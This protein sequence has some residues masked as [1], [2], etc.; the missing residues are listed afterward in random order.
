MSGNSL[1]ALL[2]WM[3]EDSQMLKW[4]MIVALERRK[5]N[6][7]MIQEYI[8]RFDVGSYLP[9]IRGEITIV[10]NVYMNVVHDFVMDVPLL[11]FENAN[12][13]D[14]RAMLTMSVVGGSEFSLKRESF[15]WKA[16]MV[17]EIDPL[18]GPKLYLD[19]L[20]D[21]VPGNVELNG[22][23]ILDLSKSDNFRLTVGQTPEEHRLGGG[24]FKDLFNTLPADKRIWPLGS[25]EHGTSDVMRPESFVLRTQS[26]GAAAHDPRS[27]EHGNGAILA[28]IRM[29]GSDGGNYP[30][31]NYKYLIPDD[32]GKDYSA[33]VLFDWARLSTELGWQKA[34]IDRVKSLFAT[35]DLEY[36]YR[37]DQIES[38]TVKSGSFLVSGELEHEFLVKTEDGFAVVTIHRQPSIVPAY[39][40]L[41]PFTLVFSARGATMHW[42]S[43]SVE[44]VDIYY[45]ENNSDPVGPYH[46][47]GRILYALEAVFELK[48]VVG[49]DGV[50][51]PVISPTTYDFYITKSLSEEQLDWSRA[52]VVPDFLL[53]FIALVLTAFLVAVHI[54]A[55]ETRVRLLLFVTL[56]FSSRFKSLIKSIIKLNFGQAM[57]TVEIRSP[58][59]IAYF[60]RINP[61]RTSF[62]INPMR[63]LMQQ[64]DTQQFST[65]PPIDTGLLWSVENLPN[66][67]GDP[68]AISA[69]GL[70]EAP[71]AIMGRFKRVR[72]T[73]TAPNSDYH[74]SA[75]VTV[76]VHDLSVHP[77]IQVCDFSA[78]VEL[79]AGSLKHEELTWSIKNPVENESGEV[80]PSKK[81]E[82]DH[83]Y[84][85]GPPVDGKTYVLDEIEVKNSRTNTTRSAHVLVL[86]RA[87][88]LPVKILNIDLVQGQVQLEAYIN[89]NLV[90]AEW[91]LPMGGPGSIDSMGLYRAS[92]SATE[93]FVLI[94]AVVDAGPPYGKFEGHLIL[95]L[96]LVE[97]PELFKVLSH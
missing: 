96:P 7:L 82:G 22:R 37:D 19:L 56:Y 30:E 83:T 93:R 36:T 40:P 46:V 78:T 34:L 48:E 89:G 59:D 66:D 29:A 5:A 79:T 26:S 50:V 90:D 6:L 43:E 58:R 87:S 27:S 92:P 16:E 77:L 17:D 35:E 60:G 2:A 91:S 25:I 20:L 12:L 85:P 72:V 32:A 38:V 23:V 49:L 75:L 57:E 71:Q 80:R 45:K 44:I 62:M 88:G 4:G 65:D 41:T 21:Q 76:L 68:G 86:H 95:P 33:T 13:N 94:F 24:F 73:A 15:G 51:A 10:E 64:G 61:A 69:T 11:S 9:P 54:A 53:D 1:E 74:S 42:Q 47:E 52:K 3:K 14:S 28:L 18:S 55:S 81:P 84:H 67:T 63:P 97:F 39:S 70:Y 31:G 8:R